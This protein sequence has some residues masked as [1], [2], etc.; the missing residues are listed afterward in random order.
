MK[1]SWF[2]DLRVLDVCIV[3]QHLAKPEAVHKDEPGEGL[4]GTHQ[5][6]YLS[7]LRLNSDTRHIHISLFL[8]QSPKYSVVSQIHT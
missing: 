1:F 6:S 8:T 3:G 5:K 4:G 7:I 2:L